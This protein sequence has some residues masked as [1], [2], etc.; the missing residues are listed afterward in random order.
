MAVNGVKPAYC[1]PFEKFDGLQTMKDHLALAIDKI[2]R[3]F[4]FVIVSLPFRI[5]ASIICTVMWR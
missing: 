3:G 2:D 5:Y 4:K 1:S